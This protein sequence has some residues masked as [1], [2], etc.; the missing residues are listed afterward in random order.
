MHCANTLATLVGISPSDESAQ[1]LWY[2]AKAALMKQG[3]AVPLLFRVAFT[4]DAKNWMK[5]HKTRR[6]WQLP[7]RQA[8]A[9]AQGKA[10]LPEAPK[11]HKP[12]RQSGGK[13]KREKLDEDGDAV[14]VRILVVTEEHL[15]KGHQGRW[16]SAVLGRTSVNECSEIAG[17]GTALLCTVQPRC[18]PIAGSQRCAGMQDGQQPRGRGNKRRQKLRSANDFADDAPPH[19]RLSSFLADS[20]RQDGAHS[21]F[22]NEG[23]HEEEPAEEAKLHKNAK[24]AAAQAE[25]T[26]SNVP[27]SAAGA[28][29]TA[30]AEPVAGSQL[31]PA[32]IEAPVGQ[33]ADD[34][35]GASS[36]ADME[37]E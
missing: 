1:K 36:D 30:G 7:V 5:Q 23:M 16:L 2:R 21:Y 14:M 35:E 11:A 33:A 28:E 22:L 26:D 37:V 10:E 24:H 15:V 8:V 20:A 19:T 31:Q 25:H 12:Q 29:G 27:L 13:A 9:V 34:A 4:S 3:V 6:L 18:T 32:H 17:T